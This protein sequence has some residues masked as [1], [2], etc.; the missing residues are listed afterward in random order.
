MT[1][2]NGMNDGCLVAFNTGTDPSRVFI[3]HTSFHDERHVLNGTDVAGRITL[4]NNNVRIQ[5]VGWD[6]IPATLRG[7]GKRYGLSKW[8]A[9]PGFQPGQRERP[10]RAI[11]CLSRC[12]GNAFAERLNTTR[13]VRR[14][15]LDLIQIARIQR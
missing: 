9:L 1:E 3:D 7:E 11:G 5:P 12:L 15:L 2:R 13:A 8:D 4:R 6:V 14:V 10:S